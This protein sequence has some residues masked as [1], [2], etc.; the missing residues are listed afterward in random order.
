MSGGPLVVLIGPMGVGKSTVGALL[1]E[2]L[3]VPFLDTD[4]DVVH[5]TGRSVAE[6]VTEDGE[7]RFRELEHEAVARAAAG[8]PGVLALGGGAVGHGGSRALLAGLPVV[9]LDVDVAEAMR[10]IGSDTGRPLLAADPERRWQELQ[11]ERRALYLE[12]ARF[13]V[14]TDGRT[15]GQVARIIGRGVLAD[16][17]GCTG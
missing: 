4:Q 9:L 11:D 17:T 14:R 2:R 12:V 1:A 15:P 10:R 7:P 13:V 6:I 5:R 3:G 8:F 16:R